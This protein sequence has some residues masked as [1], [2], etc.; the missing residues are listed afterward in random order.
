MSGA[1]SSPRAPAAVRRT[2]SRI[3]IY[4]AG[5]SA[6]L[7]G[8]CFV[9]GGLSLGLSAIVGGVVAVLNWL[10]MRWIGERVMVANERGRV[11]WGVLFALKMAAVVAVIGLLLEFGGVDP[12]GFMIGM[13]GF[14]AGL[15]LGGFT[16]AASADPVGGSNE[17]GGA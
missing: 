8:L 5:C 2:M 4:I 1:K 7:A 6:V 12:L 9:A 13:S 10:A 14:V 17:R 11:R 3:T 15:L 16:H